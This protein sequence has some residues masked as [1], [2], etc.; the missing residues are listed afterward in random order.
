MSRA[1][2]WPEQDAARE[3]SERV[4]EPGGRMDQPGGSSSRASRPRMSRAEHPGIVIVGGGIAGLIAADRAAGRGVPVL[5]L[6]AGQELGGMLRSAPLDGRQVNIGADAYAVRG[7]AVDALLADLGMS[8]EAI[9]PE[10]LGAW[11][12]TDEGACRLPSTGVLGIPAEIDEHVER[13]LGEQG[14][15]RMRLDLRMGPEPGA[16]A[17]NLAELIEARLGRAALDRLITPV[18]RGVYSLDPAELDHRVLLPGI[19]A[20]LRERGSLMAAIDGI[21]RA[22][23]PGAHVRGTMRLARITAALAARARE[24]GAKLLSR[25]RVTGIEAVPAAQ[26]ERTDQGAPGGEGTLWRIRWEQAGHHHECTAPAV[27]VT[28]PLPPGAMPCD[29][30]GAL[31]RPG[32][33]PARVVLLALDA[34]ELDAAPRGTGV[35]T[36]GQAGGARARALTHVTA[37]WP[38]LRD[39]ALREGAPAGWHVLRLSYG[40]RDD[41]PP[42]NEEAAWSGAPLRARAIRDASLLLGVPIGAGQ[43]R[44]AA[45]ALW[46]LPAPAAR[47]GAQAWHAAVRERAAQLAGFEVAGTWM[48]GTGLASVVPGAWRATD[49]LLSAAA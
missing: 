13:A 49:R 32:P 48:D 46:V 40:P 33:V 3:G 18:A 24:R 45:T 15:A 5:L 35:L 22:A 11:A 39:E 2:P 41:L 8:G 10:A 23:P 25:A 12:V 14:T 38:A 7:G 28:V 30:A 20:R 16:D 44:D 43:L 47:I 36:A 37:K 1:D 6:D 29:P 27:L 19:D 34:P 42:L 9:E 4:H 21:R 26:R 31:P 17:A